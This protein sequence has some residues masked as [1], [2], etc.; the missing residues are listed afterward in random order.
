MNH[1]DRPGFSAAPEWVT[2]AI[3]YQVFPDRF[4]RSTELTRCERFEAWDVKPTRE[5]F[6]GGDLYG[7]IEN[8]GVLEDLGVTALY[9]NPIFSAACN[10]RYHT[11]DYMQVDPLLGGDRAFDALLAAVEKRGMRIILDGVFNHTGRGFWAFHHILENGAKSPYVDWYHVRSFPLKA[12]AKRGGANYECW[13]DI[14][15]LPKLNT[16]NPETR[17]YL[18]QVAEHWIRRGAHGW[19]L[20]VPNEIDDAE[21]WRSFRRRVRSANPDAY[22]VGELW[23]EAPEWVGGDRFDGVM[24]YPLAQLILG[25]A[26]GERLNQKQLGSLK[27]RPLDAG[28]ASA[29]LRRLNLV[30]PVEVQRAHL[31]LLGSHD[32]PRLFTLLRGDIEALRLAVLFQMTLPGAPCI[33][34]GDELG[35]EGGADPACRGGYPRRPTEAQLA[36]RAMFQRAVALRR[37]RPLLRHGA[38]RVLPSHDNAVVFERYDSTNPD[39]K[40]LI[41]LNTTPDIVEVEVQLGGAREKHAEARELWHGASVLAECSGSQGIC[42][43]VPPKDGCVLQLGRS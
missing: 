26:A 22:L 34:Y 38:L 18:L 37:S 12:Y 25:F 42:V 9:L 35:L 15:A 2:D 17:E 23:E 20:D 16:S 29:E 8:L 39:A 32:T 4:A 6:K 19:R 7:V 41:A 10:H 33:Y 27:A 30:Y 40:I 11:Y 43:R 24:N 31:N 1:A 36:I 3:F 5:G 28:E 13:W 21:F 14:P